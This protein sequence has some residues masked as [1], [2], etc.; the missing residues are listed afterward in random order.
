[1]LKEKR[2]GNEEESSKK[3]NKEN[4]KKEW[5]EIFREATLGNLSHDDTEKERAE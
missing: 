3:S 4:R 5:D 2:N 1:L